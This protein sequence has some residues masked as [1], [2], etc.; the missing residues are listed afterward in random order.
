M[1]G[2]YVELTAADLAHRWRE[3]TVLESVDESVV[4][5]GETEEYATPESALWWLLR[6]AWGD[7]E[8]AR[9]SALNGRWSM[10]CDGH[11]ERIVGLT[12]LVGI[13]SWE[14]VSVDLILDGVYERIHE[15]MGS[16]TPLTDDDRRRAQGVKD[17]RAVPFSTRHT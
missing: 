12:R 6:L 11:V 16:P 15:A 3:R 1:S 17:R 9:K 5:A 4:Q 10:T 14:H 2:E 8:S 7:L 13:L